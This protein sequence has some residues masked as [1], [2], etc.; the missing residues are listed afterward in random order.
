MPHPAVVAECTVQP[1]PGDV[2]VAS[3]HRTVRSDITVHVESP[4]ATSLVAS[5]AGGTAAST[6]STGALMGAASTAW[7]RAG[8]WLLPDCRQATAA[9]AMTKC[10]MRSP[11]HPVPYKE[12]TAGAVWRNRDGDSRDVGDRCDRVS[13]AETPRRRCK[14]GRMAHTL[15]TVHVV[16]AEPAEPRTTPVSRELGDGVVQRDGAGRARD[17][18]R[19][20]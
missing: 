6:A 13:R 12:H 14:A 11:N 2:G 9:S 17:R 5:G 16:L 4:D 10:A 8:G 19:S 20:R 1:Q 18:G 7:R 3:Q 15:T